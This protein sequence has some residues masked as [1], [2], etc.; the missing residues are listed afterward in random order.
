MPRTDHDA[1][2]QA[3]E[4]ASHFETAEPNPVR[5]D[6]QAALADLQRA[7][8]ERNRAE[9]RIRA[10]VLEARR[11]GASWALIAAALGTSRQAAHQRY[12]KQIR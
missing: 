4:L 9:T 3:A 12:G 5:A 7:V 1:P 6:A 2:E 8:V 11:S 10:A